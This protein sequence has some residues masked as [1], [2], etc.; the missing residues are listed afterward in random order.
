M[1]TLWSNGPQA[2]VLRFCSDFEAAWRIVWPMFETSTFLSP[3]E[4]AARAS[5]RASIARLRED[6]CT[7]SSGFNPTG[8]GRIPNH[9][10][11]MEE[12]VNSTVRGNT[13]C[14]ITKHAR[15]TTLNEY[16]LRMEGA[17]WKIE[18]IVK[19]DPADSK[20]FTSKQKINTLTRGC[21]PHA[22]LGALPA[23]QAQMDE[24]FNFTERSVTRH[25]ETTRTEI[26]RIGTL[27]TSSG[28]LAVLDFGSDN[29]D[30]RPL[31]RSV[32]QGAYPV[33]RVTG[34]GR[35]AAV[36]V[37]FSDERPTSWHPARLPDSGH[38]FS[39]DAGC[40]CVA[41]YA[42]Y[43]SMTPRDKAALHGD[44]IAD[45]RPAAREF[46]LGKSD[47]GVVFD[48]GFGDGGY[49]AY[50][51]MDTQRRVTQLVID[52]LVL[53]AHDDDGVIRHL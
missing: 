5:W 4:E 14:V 24:L 19:I 28:V 23:A 17:D 44:F 25:G 43:A 34:F 10:S 6:H 21:S 53:T 30:A 33:E 35:N 31:A 51:G 13:A 7:E 32:A 11:E 20:P 3:E 50:W 26:S 27:T 39:V 46:P 8:I 22:E 42:A 41:D 9:S 37:L 49:P 38:V 29:S 12:V 16:R 40:A 48:S 15:F 52:F 1:S 45:Q 18:K 2:R 47:V 36:R